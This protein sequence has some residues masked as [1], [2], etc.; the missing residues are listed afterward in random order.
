MASPGNQRCANCIGTLP[1]PVWGPK[2]QL[3]LALRNGRFDVQQS[4]TGRSRLL[5]LVS[6]TLC[7]RR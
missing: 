7:R 1:F 2:R 5:D 3:K 6:G 4:V